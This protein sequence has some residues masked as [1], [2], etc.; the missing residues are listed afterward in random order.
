[1]IGERI[2]AHVTRP[3][4]I[5]SSRWT[6]AAR[7]GTAT[8]GACGAAEESTDAAGWLA[9][10]EEV[11]PVSPPLAGSGTLA[12]RGQPVLVLRQAAPNG[13]EV[14]VLDQPRHGPHRP[15]TERAVVDLDDRRH[16]DARPAQEHLIGD[17]QLAAIDRP[18][19]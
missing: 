13:V 3:G 1:M 8:S 11:R 15:R 4:T 19:L 7:R 6:A 18:D 10:G 9:R 5:S 12:D 2:R 14:A 17:V 16:L